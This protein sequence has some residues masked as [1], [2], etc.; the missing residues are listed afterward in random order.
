M[1]RLTD[2]VRIIYLN[3]KSFKDPNS[4]SLIIS[5]C[6]LYDSGV[7][8]SDFWNFQKLKRGNL[9]SWGEKILQNG[10]II[11]SHLLYFNFKSFNDPN[12]LSFL[13]FQCI[14]HHSGVLF[15]E[16]WNFYKIKRGNL[17]SGWNQF[18][19]TAEL[20]GS[21]FCISILKASRTQILR[22][23]LDFNAFCMIQENFSYTF[24]ISTN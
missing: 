23:S 24:E 3:F 10:W 6:I 7:P 13:R 17:V 12:Y 11:C 14:L 18:R 19:R 15:S 8:F 9:T 16:S 20:F 22:H 2:F 4:L 21:L 5:Q 1:T